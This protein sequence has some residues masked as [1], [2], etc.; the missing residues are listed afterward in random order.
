MVLVTYIRVWNVLKK[1]YIY[2][3]GRNI[4]ALFNN[5]A[6]VRIVTSKT[7]LDIQYNKLGRRVAKRLKAVSIVNIEQV[8]VD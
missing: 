5:L 1:F 4:S 6:Q 2:N 7:I 3:P 8:N